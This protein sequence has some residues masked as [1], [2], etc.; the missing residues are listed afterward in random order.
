MGEVEGEAVVGLLALAGQTDVRHIQSLPALGY[1]QGDLVVGLLYGKDHYA[2]LL[3][4]PAGEQGQHK[5]R[6]YCQTGSFHLE[7]HFLFSIPQF[8]RKL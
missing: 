2:S 6:Q 5:E 1:G 3:L 7:C 8:S 4:V